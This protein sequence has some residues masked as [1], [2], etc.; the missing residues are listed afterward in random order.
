MHSYAMWCAVDALPTAVF[1]SA[2]L[3]VSIIGF[4][5]RLF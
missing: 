2:A 3:Q 4:K 1:V 5:V